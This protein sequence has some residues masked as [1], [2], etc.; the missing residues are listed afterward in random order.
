MR[1]AFADGLADREQRLQT[2]LAASSPQ[3]GHGRQTVRGRRPVTLR[4]PVTYAWSWSVT[5]ES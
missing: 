5:T 4:S 3:Q 1:H 2:A